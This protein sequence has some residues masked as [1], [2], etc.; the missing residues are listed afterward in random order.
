M[1]LVD[2]WRDWQIGRRECREQRG[3]IRGVICRDN[4]I[5]DFMVKALVLTHSSGSDAAMFKGPYDTTLYRFRSSSLLVP[6]ITEL[7]SHFANSRA[8]RSIPTRAINMQSANGLCI[9][10]RVRRMIRSMLWTPDL[11]SS[12]T[13]YLRLLYI[14]RHKNT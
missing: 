7:S 8:A 5:E 2:A 14:I 12:S 6:A 1:V 9:K 11:T 10:H 3:Q 13:A 4:A